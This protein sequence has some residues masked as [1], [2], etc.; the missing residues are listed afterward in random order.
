[1]KFNPVGNVPDAH[2]VVSAKDDLFPER[3][4]PILEVPGGEQDISPHHLVPLL[5]NMV[6]EVLLPGNFHSFLANFHFNLHIGLAQLVDVVED[7]AVQLFKLWCEVGAPSH[8]ARSEGEEDLQAVDQNIVEFYMNLSK[9]FGPNN[10]KISRYGGHEK[11]II[12]LPGRDRYFPIWRS[13]HT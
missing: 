6:F 3:L 5:L 11:V 7:F 12:S 2:G 9:S 13:S 10:V 1:M 4:H 8:V